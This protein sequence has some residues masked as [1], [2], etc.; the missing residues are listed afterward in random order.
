[1]YVYM[2]VCMCICI[3]VS[4]YVVVRIQA[5]LHVKED[6]HAC[7]CISVYVCACLYIC[8]CRIHTCTHTDTYMYIEVYAHSRIYVYT[9]IYVYIYIHIYTQTH[10]RGWHPSMSIHALAGDTCKRF[11]SVWRSTHGEAA[12]DEKWQEK[13]R[14]H[15]QKEGKSWE[16]FMDWRM[17][18]RTY[19]YTR[20]SCPWRKLTSKRSQA[21][22]KKR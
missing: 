2:F 15:A 21:C 4:L 11:G 17:Y 7:K 8:I 22:L 13:D 9:Y 5:R 6:I 3:Q 1:M 12:L 20:W 10:D 16:I 19:V 18:V 14:K